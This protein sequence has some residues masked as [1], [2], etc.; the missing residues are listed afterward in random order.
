MKKL[1]KLLALLTAM[2]LLFCGCGGDTPKQGENDDS[3]TYK[4]GVMQLMDHEALNLA[5]EG[6]IAALADN[7]FV[8]GQNIT[9]LLENGQG[10]TNNLNTIADKF[11]SENVDLAFCIATPS[12]EVM[13]GK[14]T[15]I[16]I[17][18]T[19]VTSFE[20]AGLVASDAAPGGNITGTSDLNP[21]SDQLDLMLRLFPD[22]KTVGFVYTSSEDNSILQCQI[23]KEYLE[24]KNIKTVERTITN[25]N[26]IQQAVQAIVSE[27]DAL[28][29]PTDNNMASSMPTV[30]NITQPAGIPT[31]CGE[32]NMVKKGGTATIGI[33]YY[34][35]GYTAG[36]MAIDI[37]VNGKDPATMAIQGSSELEY[38]LNGDALAAFNVEVPEDLQPYVIHPG[39]NTDDEA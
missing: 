33:T 5:Q 38:C 4:I 22:V 36:E 7:G 20:K 24:T 39:E 35:I 8:N 15:T 14:T 21:V 26:D 11:V 1:I 19:A 13:A 18:A 37:L 9:L 25:T 12:T 3:Q 34:G 16:P 31:I 27:C 23:A 32:S 6:F 28:Y 30:T 17:V 2:S 29:I 10:D